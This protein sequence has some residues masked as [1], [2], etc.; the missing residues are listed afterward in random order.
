[1]GLLTR[2]AFFFFFPSGCWSAGLRVSIVKGLQEDT[3][4]THMSEDM[5]VGVEGENAG[6]KKGVRLNSE[7]KN[8]ELKSEF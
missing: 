7:D 5:T 8:M 3:C 4:T 2:D 1:M 6:M